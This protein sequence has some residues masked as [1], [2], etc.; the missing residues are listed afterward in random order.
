MSTN[1]GVIT[2]CTGLTDLSLRDM[3]HLTNE[4]VQ[5]IGRHCR[6]LQTLDISCCGQITDAAFSTLNVSVLTTLNV[7]HTA[8]TGSFASSLLAPSSALRTLTCN[9]GT[10][11]HEAFVASISSGAPLLD[12]CVSG[13]N[14]SREDWIELSI[15]LPCLQAITSYHSA[16]LTTNVKAAMKQ[17][18]HNL[19]ILA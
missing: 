13:N 15:L 17:Q 4:A 1:L 18:N 10:H 12:I 3:P 7:S 5:E 16:T 14:F 11:L 6:L 9:F 19:N 8:V 2:S